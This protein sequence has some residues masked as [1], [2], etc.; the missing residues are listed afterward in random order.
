MIA[1]KAML[2]DTLVAVTMPFT[3]DFWTWALFAFVRIQFGAKA[4]DELIVFF[5]F[6]PMVPFGVWC[7]PLK[8]TQIFPRKETRILSNLVFLQTLFPAARAGKQAPKPKRAVRNLPGSPLLGSALEDHYFK[9]VY[10]C[11][12]ETFN[13]FADLIWKS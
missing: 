9:G 4:F 1:V 10:H 13:G 12:P 3:M 2:P 11:P 8:F 7:L 6:H 5:F